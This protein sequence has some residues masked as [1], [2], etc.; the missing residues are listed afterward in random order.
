MAISIYTRF[1]KGREALEKG[2]LRTAESHLRPITDDLLESRSINDPYALSALKE[3]AALY[4]RQEHTEQAEQ[5]LK[6]ALKKLQLDSVERSKLQNLL[7][8]VEAKRKKLSSP[9]QAVTLSAHEPTVLEEKLKSF[10]FEASPQKAV[11]ALEQFPTVTEALDEFKPT[12]RVIRVDEVRS[13]NQTSLPRAAGKNGEVVVLYDQ[14][15]QFLVGEY[16]LVLAGERYL[17]VPHSAEGVVWKVPISELGPGVVSGATAKAWLSSLEVGA[18]LEASSE[19][20]R[21]AWVAQS[22]GEAALADPEANNL[23]PSCL[24]QLECHPLRVQEVLKRRLL[25]FPELVTLGRAGSKSSTSRTAVDKQTEAQHLA[26][27]AVLTAELVTLKDTIRAIEG[28]STKVA[29]KEQSE[30]ARLTKLTEHLEESKKSITT[31]LVKA[32]SEKRELAKALAATESTVD[33]LQ[34]KISALQKY[35]AEAPRLMV[36]LEAARVETTQ[37]MSKVRRLEQ[38]VEFWTQ[39]AQPD[40]KP[41]APFWQARNLRKEARADFNLDEFAH[42]SFLPWLRQWYSAVP[43]GQAREFCQTLLAGY[44]TSIQ[45]AGPIKAFEIASRGQCVL[46]LVYCSPR[47]LDFQEVWDSSLKSIWSAAAQ[48]TQLHIV[49][50]EGC[51]QSLFSSWGRPLLGLRSGV[52]DSLPV[53]GSNGWLRNLRLC[54][55]DSN[56]VEELQRNCLPLTALPDS[57]SIEESGPLPESDGPSLPWPQISDYLR[58][59]E[60]PRLGGDRQRLKL[61]AS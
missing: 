48:S 24:K 23:L 47:W 13:L 15:G 61:L 17:C 31:E 54:F 52:V 40:P 2:D 30:N 4:N 38:D 59:C 18:V 29:L 7:Y 35:Q 16:E 41:I 20:K 25:E 5:L 42:H 28:Q 46:H 43:E 39:A 14:R 44:W 22:L 55:V 26:E 37:L 21:K 36:Q 33:G 56:G 34:V 50:F 58:N 6:S 1:Q 9:I 11:A 19:S 3:L 8:N 51:N 57:D 45:E 12:H 53:D 60:D 10:R 49:L 27:R 32:M